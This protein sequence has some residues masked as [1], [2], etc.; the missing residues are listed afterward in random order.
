MLSVEGANALT[1]CCFLHLIT[2]KDR[3]G[4]RVTMQ[5]MAEPVCFL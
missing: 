3:S 4:V 2:A 5:M 1:F